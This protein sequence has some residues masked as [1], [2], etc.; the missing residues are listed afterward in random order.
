MEIV[1]YMKTV[2]IAIVTNSFDLFRFENKMWGKL[3]NEHL[4]LLVYC[5]D[6][7]FFYLCVCLINTYRLYL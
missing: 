6:S 3:K 7:D 4:T 2:R 1:G 5:F